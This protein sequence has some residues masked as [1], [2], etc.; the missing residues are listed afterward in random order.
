VLVGLGMTDEEEEANSELIE[1]TCTRSLVGTLDVVYF[2][3][4]KD[5]L[6]TF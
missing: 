1:L 4:V 6:R 2:L 3:S 5:R